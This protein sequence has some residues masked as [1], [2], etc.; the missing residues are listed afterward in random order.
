MSQ[1]TPP[2][3]SAESNS[4]TMKGKHE[5]I[6]RT[7]NMDSETRRKSWENYEK[8]AGHDL[9]EVCNNST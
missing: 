8:H 2:P 4:E 7:L 5:E 9:L 6:C 3:V 1:S